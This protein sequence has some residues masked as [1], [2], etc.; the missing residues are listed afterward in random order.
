MM[1]PFSCFRG[2][3]IG[4]HDRLD[5]INF[6]VAPDY[7]IEDVP[8]GEIELFYDTRELINKFSELLAERED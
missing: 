2:I 1:A 3:K 6:F 5:G 7:E 4:H 8:K